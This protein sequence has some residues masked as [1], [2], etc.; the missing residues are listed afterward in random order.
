[1]KENMALSGTREAMRLSAD[2]LQTLFHLRRRRMESAL[3]GEFRY[4]WMAESRSPSPPRGPI[5]LMMILIDWPGPGLS[6]R[7]VNTRLS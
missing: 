5:R 4:E 3:D 2:S 7:P 6:D 1:M